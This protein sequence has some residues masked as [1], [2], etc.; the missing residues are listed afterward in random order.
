MKNIEEVLRSLKIKAGLVGESR[1]LGGDWHIGIFYD[2]IA[3]SFVATLSFHGRATSMRLASPMDR[4]EAADI[5]TK[6]KSP[7]MTDNTWR[8]TPKGIA[9]VR[10]SALAVMAKAPVKNQGETL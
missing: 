1:D 8:L 5:S 6:G 7:W 4:N 2:P 10:S 3:K 9:K